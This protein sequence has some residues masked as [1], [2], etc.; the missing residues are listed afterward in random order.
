MGSHRTHTIEYEAGALHLDLPGTAFAGPV[1][2][3]QPLQ[4]SITYPEGAGPWKLLLFEHGN[5]TTCITGGGE[6]IVPYP[7]GPNLLCPDIEGP[8]GQQEQTRIRNYAGYEYLSTVL[9]SHGYVVVSPSANLI[10]STQ[11]SSPDFGA[12]QRAE[13]IGATLDLMN[14]WNNGTGPVVPGDPQRSVGTKLTGRV[15]LEHVGLMGHSRGG[16]AVTRF[17]E[18]NAT[19]TPRYNINGVVAVGPTDGGSQAPGLRAPG[20]NWAVLVPSCDGD[21]LDEQGANAF[22]RA[23]VAPGE[24]RFARFQWLVSGANHDWYNT[25]WTQE[26]ALWNSSFPEA[27]DDSACSRASPTSVR[28]SPAGQRLTG[29]ALIGGF[30]RRYVG[31]ERRFDGLLQD[32]ARFP[33]SACSSLRGVPCRAQV[34]TS[35]IAPHR[36]VLI[37]PGQEHPTSRN[38]LGGRLR[39]RGLAKLAWCDPDLGFAF[40]APEPQQPPVRRCPGPETVIEGGVPTAVVNRSWTPQ[41][42]VDWNHPA[43]LVAD[44][45]RASGN[46]SRFRTLSFR[47][48]VNVDRRNPKPRANRAVPA[49]QRL[50]VVVRDRDGEEASVAADRVSSALYPSVGNRVRQLLLNDV[51]IPLRSFR[52]VD[53]RQVAAVEL[54]FGVR[55]RRTG[56]IQLADLAFQR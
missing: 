29:L 13:I 45:P 46:V 7:D 17:L 33:D 14:R 22:E 4:G 51:R 31:G 55:G 47:T 12:T 3:D 2:V 18:L 43:R 16:E 56:S 10:T 34:R 40:G 30:L 52:G 20:T 25:V 44:V 11:A 38:A 48:A 32:G 8:D 49:T 27:I 50:D 23:K 37:G 26:D 9:A 21:V 15:E 6:F 1:S 53:L 35:Y 41:L 19:R 36:R 5:H 54:R 39:A 42:V 28:L 24:R